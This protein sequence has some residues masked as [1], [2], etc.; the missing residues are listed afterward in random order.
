MENTILTIALSSIDFLNFFEKTRLLK[1]L[2]AMENA[3]HCEPLCFLKQAS[4]DQ[5]AA[6]AGRNFRRPLRACRWDGSE[7]VRL[8]KKPFMLGLLVS[9][10]VKGNNGS[11][12]RSFLSGRLAGLWQ[13][14]S[15]RCGNEALVPRS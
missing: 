12:F 4:Y 2:K 3:G 8:A 9:A 6:M 11:A 7:L 1:E 14:I 13:K 15:Q 5:I 10:F